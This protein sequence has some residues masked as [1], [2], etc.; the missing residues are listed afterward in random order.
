M[1]LAEKITGLEM[2]KNSRMVKACGYSVVGSRETKLDR[3]AEATF[4]KLW[5]FMLLD[6]F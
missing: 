4:Q 5:S 1:I 3:E 2:E 6:L